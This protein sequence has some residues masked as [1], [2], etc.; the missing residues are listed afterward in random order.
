MID[1][2]APLA[3]R[4][5]GYI[6]DLWGTVHDGIA[7]LPGAVEC[8]RAL[9]DAGKAVLILSNAPRRVAPIVERMTAIGIPHDAYD[10]VFSSG[11]AA[12]LALRDRPDPFHAALGR[13]AFLL[14]PPDDDSVIAGLPGYTRAESIL[15]AHFILG[16]GA[17]R[18][19]D[20][21][22]DYDPLLSAAAERRLPMVCANPD[23]EVLRGDKREICAGA[24]AA[25]YEGF[26]G[27]VYYHGK[28]YPAI[29]AASLARLGI[30]DPA[31]VLAIGDSF[32]TDIAGAVAAGMDSLFITS[33]I[34]AELL[35]AAGFAAPN[36]S[37]LARIAAD[38]GARPTMAATG[39]RW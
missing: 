25:R 7:P 33:G 9:K 17:F 1:G 32:R 13:R 24:L 18:R 19:T 29:Y 37:L 10:C 34:H 8:L 4:Y 35:G 39:F 3:E 26:G 14:G 11:E 30:D 38:Y 22:A 15:G 21:V 31:R 28:P 23:L 36:P 27:A 12:F 20:S 6:V 16:I 5:D 2:L